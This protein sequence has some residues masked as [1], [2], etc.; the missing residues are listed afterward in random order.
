MPPARPAGSAPL[1]HGWPA[2]AQ[3]QASFDG[4][5]AI[6]LL[7][8]SLFDL[9]YLRDERAPTIYAGDSRELFISRFVASTDAMRAASQ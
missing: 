2:S 9:C 6:T 1:R 7:L 5:G 3:V 8:I 4:E